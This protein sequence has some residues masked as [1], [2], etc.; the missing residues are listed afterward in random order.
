VDPALCFKTQCSAKDRDVDPNRRAPALSDSVNKIK[1]AGLPGRIICCLI[2]AVG[3]F[4][5]QKP[6]VERRAEDAKDGVFQQR[7]KSIQFSF[8]DCYDFD[9]TGCKAQMTKLTK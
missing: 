9:W 1:Q 8:T 4:K 7:F 3:P 2:S 5:S 6:D